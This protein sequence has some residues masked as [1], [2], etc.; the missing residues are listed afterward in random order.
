MQPKLLIFVLTIGLACTGFGQSSSNT[1]SISLAECIQLALQHNLD[2][3]IERYAPDIAHYNLSVAYGAYD[4]LFRF[5]ARENF[6]SV[7]LQVD[8][9]KPGADFPYEL[10][11]D[12]FA[13]GILGYL[14]SGLSYE[15]SGA[16]EFLGSRT[17]LAR[18]QL[19]PDGIRLTNEYAT[20]AAITLRQPLLKDFWIDAT[21]QQIRLSRK[22]IKISE[23][24][25][26]QQIINVVTKVQ[27]S[28]YELAFA[29]EKV[30]VE[31]QALQLA[32]QLLKETK[33]RVEVGD[34]PP[35]DEKQAEAQVETVQTGV[36]AAEQ[37][38]AEEQTHLLNLLTD[39]FKSWSGGTL[40]PAENLTATATPFDRTA[41]WQKALKLRPDLLQFRLELDKRDLVVRYRFNQ[42]FPSLDVVGSYG[43][44][45]VRSTFGAAA[46]DLGDFHSPAYSYGVVLA[47]PLSNWSARK[48]HQASLALKKQTELQL[49]KLEQEILIQVDIAGKQTETEFKRVN[50]TRRARHFAEAALEAEQKKLQNGASTGFTV[51]Q[52]QRLLTEARS[53]EVRALADHNK[54][55]VQLAFSEGSTLEKL[56]LNI[57]VK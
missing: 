30:K 57:E 42:L 16:A 20:S 51:L 23:L 43:G 15:V 9:K 38:V 40:E 10:T 28:Y 4:P 34:L 18:S 46:G 37:A 19:Y 14:P 26:R 35:L 52:L 29:L 39:D 44:R 49:R 6:A 12:S 31:R 45:G 55:L 25:L 53:A 36:F 48:S 13:P 33:R 22:D 3:Q 21:R 5:G 27:L 8:P 41:S 1:R 11:V 24:A 32:A 47:V 2:V 56:P 54:A 50:S 17:E 7:P